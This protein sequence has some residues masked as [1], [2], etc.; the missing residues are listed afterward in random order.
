MKF[1]NSAVGLAFNFKPFFGFVEKRGEGWGGKLNKGFFFWKLRADTREFLISRAGEREKERVFSCHR[2][3]K[4]D[5]PRDKLE[6]WSFER[7]LG[8][9]VSLLVLDERSTDDGSYFSCYIF[10]TWNGEICERGKFPLEYS[11]WTLV[12]FFAYQIFSSKFLSSIFTF[13]L[14]AKPFYFQRYDHLSYFQT[15]CFYHLRISPHYIIRIWR[16]NNSFPVIN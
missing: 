15:L 10:M 12:E 5:F 2:E 4:I 14:V 13:L 3:E 16:T 6:F 9:A 11:A 8:R 1:R 7:K